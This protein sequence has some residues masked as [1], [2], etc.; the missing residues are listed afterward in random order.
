M[1]SPAKQ[2]CQH[3]PWRA[4]HRISANLNPKLCLTTSPA[5]SVSM[6]PTDIQQSPHHGE[7]NA[8]NMNTGK[9][10]WKLPLG[11][12]PVL[13]AK[14]MKDTGTENHGGPIVTAGGLVV[15]AATDFDKRI[16]AFNSTTGELLWEAKLPFAGVATPATYTVDGKQ[17]IVIATSGARDPKSAQGASYVAFALP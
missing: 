17:Y 10:L 5:T 12:Y 1:P 4:S 14:G 3:S 13:A 15:I 2:A 11:E 6:T 7:P 16:R 8:I 9:Y